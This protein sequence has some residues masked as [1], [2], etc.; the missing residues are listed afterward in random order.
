MTNLHKWTWITGLAAAIG[1]SCVGAEVSR[2]SN[3]S[4]PGNAAFNQGSGALKFQLTSSAFTQGGYIPPK[5]TGDGVDVSPPLKWTGVPEN[6]KS[7]A[8]ICDDP[9]APVGTWVHWVLYDI[10]PAATELPEATPK[11]EHLPNGMKQG[12]N[13]FGKVGYGGP[14]PPKGSEHRYYFKLYALDMDPPLDA[15]AHKTDLEKAMQ[16]HIVARA[17]LMGRYRR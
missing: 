13:S 3:D 16:R 15:R 4:A 8:L 14:E 2:Q 6:V 7:F 17:E 5:Y 11:L 10:P 9:D 12:I 1:L